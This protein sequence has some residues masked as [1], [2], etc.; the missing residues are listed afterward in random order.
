[1]GIFG[2]GVAW[3]YWEGKKEDRAEEA[4]VKAEV[5]RIE[6]WK[7]E[8]IDMDD[9]VS[10]DDMFA[11]LNKRLSGEGKEVALALS[12]SRSLALSLSLS[13][14]VFLPVVSVSLFLSVYLSLSLFFTLALALALC[15]SILTRNPSAL[16]PCRY[17]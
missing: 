1:M 6:K 16:S 5:E 8:F 15:L 11:S 10:D 12:L 2:G 4:R 9:V 14:S 17:L 7:K 3:S 13:F